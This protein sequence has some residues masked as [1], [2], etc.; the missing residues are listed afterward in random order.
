MARAAVASR[1]VWFEARI[2]D[3]EVT[4]SGTPDVVLG[5]RIE[6]PDPPEDGSWVQ[7]LWDGQELVI[8][9]DRFRSYPCYVAMTPDS[10]RVSPSIDRL[11]RLGANRDLD[12]AALAAFLTVGHYVGDDTAFASIRA[13]PTGCRISWRP[14]RSQVESKLPEFRSQEMT[15]QRAAEGIS[16]LVRQ[17]VSRRIPDD[18]DFDMP[19]SGGRDSRHILLALRSLGHAPTRCLTTDHYPY[20]WGG[21]VPYARELCASLGIEHRALT[22]GDPLKGELRK[23][24]LTSYSSAMHAWFLPIV[25]ALEGRTSHTYEGTPGGTPLARMFLKGRF[26]ELVEHRRWDELA[27]L[28]GKKDGG[29]ARHIPLLVPELR[30]VLSADRAAERIRRELRRY[31]GFDDPYMAYRMLNRTSRELAL[32]PNALLAAI[33]TVYTPFYDVDL[34][35][36]A[37]S[38]PNDVIDRSFHDD[39]IT[40]RYPESN[41]AP[42]KPHRKSIAS[43]RFL[44]RLDARL[45]RF[46]IRHGR[47][48]LVDRNALI[49]RSATGSVTGSDWIVFGRRFSLTAYLIQLEALTDP[50]VPVESPR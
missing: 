22:P 40:L 15:R 23:N 41:E 12:E 9:N 19:L 4:T 43:R 49:R 5:H 13:L 25:D 26:R 48:T 1:D 29:V 17:A 37:M 3:G 39:A 38:V 18:P 35:E 20:D 47:G 8:T 34:L 50:H 33:P 7:W 24:R 11:L 16:E 31:E 44:R 28:M 10:I 21:D 32:V 30:G 14:G 46:V 27:A 36:F 45:L 2:V 42:F 6:R